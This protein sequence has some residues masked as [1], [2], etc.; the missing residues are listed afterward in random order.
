MSGVYDHF[1]MRSHLRLFSYKLRE[2]LELFATTELWFVVVERR[3][4]QLAFKLIGFSI[5]MGVLKE[6][7]DDV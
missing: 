4:V 6:D 3:V 2:V 1:G 5:L 7:C